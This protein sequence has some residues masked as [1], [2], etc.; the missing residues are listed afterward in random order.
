M[1]ASRS[2]HFFV[3]ATVALSV[4]STILGARAVVIHLSA[5]VPQ[6]RLPFP[7]LCAVVGAVVTATVLRPRLWEWDRVATRRASLVSV[8]CALSGMLLPVVIVLLGSTRLP[9]GVPWSWQVSNYLVFAGIAF[10][11]GPVLGP[12]LAGGT[13]LVLYLGCGVVNHLAPWAQDVLPVTGYPGPE[14]HWTVASSVVL[15]ALVVHGRTRGA[16]RWSR[17]LTD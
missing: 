14:T 10:C 5:A 1:L 2:F 13:T 15:L 8:A 3:A 6:N 4:L 11:L 17:R 12:A 7:E 16:T 9:P